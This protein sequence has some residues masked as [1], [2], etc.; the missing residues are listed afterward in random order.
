VCHYARTPLDRITAKTDDAGRA[1]HIPGESHELE[2]FTMD[3]NHPMI[4][5]VG[6]GFRDATVLEINMEQWQGTMFVALREVRNGVNCNELPSDCH[7]LVVRRH[8]DSFLKLD[9]QPKGT[10][11]DGKLTTAES[12]V[13]PSKTVMLSIDV[14][15]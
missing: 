5:A 15:A 4:T 11:S 12:F 2:L 8:E 14:L 6:K 10:V 1:S 7:Y 13:V 9:A 3:N